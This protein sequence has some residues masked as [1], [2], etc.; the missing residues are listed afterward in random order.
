ME[1]LYQQK[2]KVTNL[3]N[4]TEKFGMKGKEA[5]MKEMVQQ[6]E[7]NIVEPVDIQEVTTRKRKTALESLIFLTEKKDGSI[8][9]HTCANGSTQSGFIGRDEPTDIT[10]S[11]IQTAFIDAKEYRDVVVA[12][13]PN[14]L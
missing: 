8:K 9:G 11:V 2:L 4:H 5:D 10:E 12:N 14:A 7:R 13:V 6:Q 3:C 1:L